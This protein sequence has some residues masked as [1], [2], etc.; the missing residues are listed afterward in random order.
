MPST[1]G[2]D[3]LMAYS[4]WVVAL[5]PA[6]LAG[7]LSC[8]GPAAGPPPETE[9]RMVEEE[10]HGVTVQDP[11]RWLED[12]ESPETRQW[13]QQQSAY[14]ARYLDQ[15]ASRERIRRRMEEIL[16]SGSISTP[17]EAG[18]SYFYSRRADDQDQPVVYMRQGIRGED[19]VLLDPN[20]MGGD[21][22]FRA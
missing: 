6:A 14:S 12:G 15:V 11:Y 5:L 20:A 16:R 17:V 21:T 22:T 4:T 10:L 9:V 18:G 2:Y 7:L 3:G 13:I 1:E 8:G 19:R